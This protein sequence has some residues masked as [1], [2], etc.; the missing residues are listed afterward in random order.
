MLM[1][2]PIVSKLVA[3][4]M[5]RDAQATA[6]RM[7]LMDEARGVVAGSRPQFYVLR[8]GMALAAYL[9]GRKRSLPAL[10]ATSRC[11]PDSM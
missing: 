4:D 5:A 11:Q 10:A 9:V 7:R 6:A 1:V 3:D 8:D 2:S